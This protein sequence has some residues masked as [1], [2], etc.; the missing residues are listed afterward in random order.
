[1]G[2]SYDAKLIFNAVSYIFRYVQRGKGSMDNHSS[3]MMIFW[4]SPM[5]RC[6]ILTTVQ[7][8]FSSLCS[9]YFHSSY[10]TKIWSES[11]KMEVGEGGGEKKETFLLSTPSFLCFCS[12]SSF[13]SLAE[14]ETL[15]TQANI[16]LITRMKES[17]NSDLSPREFQ[18]KEH[19]DLRATF[20]EPLKYCRWFF[21]KL[22][23]HY[24]IWIKHSSF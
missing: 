6:G 17:P 8:H 19:F 4:R 22:L 10:C 1:M 11:K 5:L 23:Q 9:K 18:W 14:V 15:A 7:R 24:E 13:C 20:S 3:M 21:H 2:I 16:S 12:C